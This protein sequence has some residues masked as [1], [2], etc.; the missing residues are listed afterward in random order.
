MRP[1]R[2][3]VGRTVVRPMNT[4]NTRRNRDRALIALFSVIVVF[5]VLGIISTV[6]FAAD[7]INGT[8]AA[9][10]ATTTPPT[11]NANRQAAGDI[12]RAQAQATAVVK[13]ANDASSS[14]VKG[15]DA[16]ARRQAAA[17]VA[18]AKKQAAAVT[19]IPAPATAPYSGQS[20]A[21]VQPSSGATTYTYPTATPYAVV[22]PVTGSS[23]SGSSV[24]NLS[25]VPSSWMVVGY[26]ATF[27]SGPGTAGSISV[28]NRSSHTFSGVA[29]VKYANGGVATAPFSGLGPGGSLTLPLNGP[30]YTGGGYS[31]SL[32]GLH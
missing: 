5:A 7:H 19:P 15:A 14:I 10:G 2:N 17:I 11:G 24:P 20:T 18:A 22:T 28:L 23:T 13:A 25:G 4:Q 9:A 32:S 3:T 12:A 30:K 29:T 1:G 16:K 6:V 21:P 27:G 31:I 8:K 26:N